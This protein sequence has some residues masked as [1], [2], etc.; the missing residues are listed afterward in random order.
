MSSVSFFV[1]GIPSAQ[2]SKRHVGHGVLVDMNKNLQSWRDSIIYAA[3]EARPK[4]AGDGVVFA[5]PVSVDLTF[6]FG[7]PKSHYCSGSK[8]HLLRNNAPKCK[9]SA[10]DIDKLSRAVLDAITAAGMW[11]DDAQV[12]SLKAVKLYT[13]PLMG[14]PGLSIKLSGWCG[15]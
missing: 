2:G 9:V 4:D 13:H 12:V 8:S 3:R 6:F 7:R 10:P 1:P 11:R 5:G 14:P 15:W